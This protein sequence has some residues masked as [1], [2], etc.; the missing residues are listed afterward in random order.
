M[1]RQLE[2]KIL[3]LAITNTITETGYDMRS[4]PV[5]STENCLIV[6]AAGT[7]TQEI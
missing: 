5:N 3:V 6:M 7:N 4:I 1:H 2:K